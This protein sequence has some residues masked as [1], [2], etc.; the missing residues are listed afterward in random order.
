MSWDQLL[1]G[2]ILFGEALLRC[3]A[4]RAL[5]LGSAFS[6]HFVEFSCHI[7]VCKKKLY[8]FVRNCW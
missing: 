8:D 5:F 7:L 4:M 3:A 2:T 1:S 6:M